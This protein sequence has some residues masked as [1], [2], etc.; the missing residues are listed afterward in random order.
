[1]KALR[2]FG[3]NLAFD[4]KH[5]KALLVMILPIAVYLIIFH[6]LPMCGIV[7]ALSS[8]ISHRAYLAA[9]GAGGT[10]FASSSCQARHGR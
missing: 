4:F 9:R 10:I 5:N 8:T 3:R 1:M 6:Y 7:I 2:R